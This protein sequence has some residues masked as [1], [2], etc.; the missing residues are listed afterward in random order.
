MTKKCYPIGFSS[1]SLQKKGEKIMNLNFSANINEKDNKILEFYPEKQQISAFSNEFVRN[2]Y[3]V[4]NL[5]DEVINVKTNY[6]AKPEE[7]DQYLD[8][9]ECLCFQSQTLKP[10]E[11]VKMPIKFQ[12][13]SEIDKKDI[14]EIEINYNIML[15]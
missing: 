1:I 12:I 7:A 2:S 15:E 6:K 14:K 3:I 13:K 8:K 9:I 11:E 4:K 5:S 10:N